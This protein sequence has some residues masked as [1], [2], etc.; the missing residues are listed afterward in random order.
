MKYFLSILGSNTFISFIITIGLFNSLPDYI[1]KY[2]FTKYSTAESIFLMTIAVSFFHTFIS[3]M[4]ESFT[5]ISDK[6]I[7]KNKKGATA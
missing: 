3:F 7:S 4:M 1:M 5:F 2:D 6:F